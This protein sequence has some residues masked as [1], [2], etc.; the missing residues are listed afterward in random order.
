MLHIRTT[1]T[2]SKATAIQIVK[3]I[4]RKMII[5]KHIGSAHDSNEIV[6]LKERAALWIEKKN[7]QQ[8]LFRREFSSS[9]P[10][11]KDYQ[12]VGFRYGLLYELLYG[13]CKKFGFH[14]LRNKL[15]LDLVIARVI[16]PTSKLQSIEFLKTSMG[17]EHRREYLYRQLPKFFNLKGMVESKVLEV[18]RAEFDFNLSVVFYDVTTLYFESSS[19]DELRQCGFSKDNKFNQP[20]I[21]LGLIVNAGGF[22]MGYEILE[23]K[24]FEGHTL[25]PVIVSFKQQHGIEKLTAVADAAMI[26]KENIT[27]LIS[28]KL[29][30]IVGA[31]VANLSTE[32]IKSVSSNLMMQKGATIRIQTECGDLVCEFSSKRYAK[33]KREMENLITKAEKLL[34]NPG[35]IKRAKFITSEHETYK[36]NGALIEKTKLLLGIKGYYTNLP[37][38][39]VSDQLVIDHYHNL[40]H[41]EQVFRITKSDLQIRPIHH[42]NQRMI[43]VHI[44][45]CFMALAICKYLEMNLPAASSGVSN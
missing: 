19:T 41:V 7:Q 32:T 17:I 6:K 35:S 33:D 9:E 43:E 37:K 1:R 20:Q 12:Y 5:V 10:Q 38:S 23:G 16:E 11:L 4:N 31:R 40:W 42:F 27:A 36:L 34:E 18:A 25:I 28:A 13:L 39:G 45:I 26:S 21:V 22:P 30:Y 29:S 8:T 2:S 14:Y 3:Y 15:L 24:K 44:L